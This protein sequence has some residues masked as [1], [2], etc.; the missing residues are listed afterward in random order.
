MPIKT[1]ADLKQILI[2]MSELVA[3]GKFV[4]L[5]YAPDSRSFEFI[6][7]TFSYGDGVQIYF[8]CTSCEQKFEM[9]ANTYHGR[10]GAIEM[11]EEIKAE[12]RQDG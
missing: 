12:L 8:S 2:D 9:Y 5:G 10:G 3:E 1:R 4:S 11:V 6:S 7:R